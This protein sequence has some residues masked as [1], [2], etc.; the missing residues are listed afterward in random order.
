[1]RQMQNIHTCPR[2]F[3]KK[4]VSLIRVYKFSVKISSVTVFVIIAVLS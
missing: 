3:F 2:D 1:M 4:K